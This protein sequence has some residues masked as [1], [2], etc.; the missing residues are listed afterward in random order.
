MAAQ[1]L[2]EIAGGITAG[3]LA[4]AGALKAVSAAWAK[5]T[6]TNGKVA[7]APPSIKVELPEAF[8]DA[9]KEQL[10]IAQRQLDA[11]HELH[12]DLRLFVI[13]QAA[14]HREINKALERLERRERSLTA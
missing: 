3:V 13:E 14:E 5:Y 6:A 9:T 10:G 1:G 7:V 12:A 8:T 4:G 2:A 11:I